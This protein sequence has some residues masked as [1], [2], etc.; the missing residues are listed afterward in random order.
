M[1][2]FD[3]PCLMC[4]CSK[5]EAVPSNPALPKSKDADEEMGTQKMMEKTE[6]TPDPPAANQAMKGTLLLFST[7]EAKRK[8]HLGSDHRL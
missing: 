7:R 8:G 5:D 2:I 1:N 3:V 6:V 4:L